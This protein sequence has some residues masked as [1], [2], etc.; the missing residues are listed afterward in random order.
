MLHSTT[1]L[2]EYLVSCGIPIY[3]VSDHGGGDLRIHFKEEAT[4][5]ERARAKVLL[6]GF[7]T[8]PR[9]LKTLEELDKDLQILPAP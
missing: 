5:E 4:E 2:H 8:R 6:A 9:R 7:D 1:R 3:G